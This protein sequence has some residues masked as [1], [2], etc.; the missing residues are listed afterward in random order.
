[1]HDEAFTYTRQTHGYPAPKFTLG[2]TNKSESEGGSLE[3]DAELPGGGFEL[4]ST[5]DEEFVFDN[6]KWA[7]P[8]D[9]ASFRIARA[10]VTQSE[11]LSFMD[12]EGYLREELWSADGWKWRQSAGAVHPVS[13][14][15]GDSGSWQR[16]DF[17]RWVDLEPNK[18]VLHVSWYEADAYCRW[19]G[20]R[21]PTEAEWEFAAS[22][23]PRTGGK[24]RYPWGDDPPTAERAN[25]DWRAMG[26][27]DVGTLPAGESPCGCRQMIGNT[28]EWTSS[29][30]DPYPGFSPDPYKD[31]SEP[32][33]GDHLVLKGGCWATRSRLID[34][35]YRNFYKPD[36]RDVWAGFR[37]CAL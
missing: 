34:N 31:Y 21:L 32:W 6:E 11:F 16:R 26:A 8:V 22:V 18:P 14:G 20:R 7:H 33:F 25:L 35:A 15:R 10:A 28:W 17:D 12:D 24:R 4:G 9:V 5:P 1:M 19:A 2:S 13:W 36:R 30:F 37:T 23:D 27:L 29:A 3:G